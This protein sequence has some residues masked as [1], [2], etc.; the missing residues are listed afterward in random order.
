MFALLLYLEFE[1][2]LLFKL[3]IINYYCLK[4]EFVKIIKYRVIL[5]KKM[6]I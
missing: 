5:Q 2:L 4:Q 1:F 3:G 6:E